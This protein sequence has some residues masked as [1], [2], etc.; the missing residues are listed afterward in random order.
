MTSFAPIVKHW[1]AGTC[2][3]MQGDPEGGKQMYNNMKGYRTWDGEPIIDP[4]TGELTTFALCGDPIAGTGWYEGPGWPDGAAAYDR[5]MQVNFG[6]FTFTPGDTNEIVFAIIMAIGDDYLDSVTELKKTTRAIREFYYT[7][8]MT[9]ID[10][11]TPTRPVR[12]TLSQNYPNLF[13]PSTTIEF[14]LPISDNVQIEIY[15]IAGQK[16]E[17]LLN[18]GMP[19]GDHKIDY[20]ARNLASGVYLYRIEA[21]RY[22]EVK[23]MVL[24]K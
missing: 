17:T 10:S 15:N 20:N 4:N 6:P 18:K 11:K 12:Y 8:V 2:D 1:F 24:L 22:Q 19:A 23:K 3:P 5:R 21:G 13:N 7:G 9:N 14:S 16:I